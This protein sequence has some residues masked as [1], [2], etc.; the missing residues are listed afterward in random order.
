M[1]L[2]PAI[3]YTFLKTPEAN[4]DLIDNDHD[5][6][7]DEPGERSGLHT[8]M[9]YFSSAGTIR[10]P[11][12]GADIYNN[13]L[14]LWVD[15]EPITYGGVGREYSNS[16]SRFIFTGDPL[17]QSYW[18]AF[19]PAPNGE[20]PPF[21]PH[22]IRAMVTSGPFT[23][24]PGESNEFLIALV[25]A[26]GINHL[27]SVRKLKN[28]VANL[29]TTPDRYLTTGYQ[30]GQLEAPPEPSF[31]L[32]FDHNFPNPFNKK[33]TLRYS[34]PK[35]MQVRLAVYDLLGREVTVLAEGTREAGI[36]TQE[37]DGAQLRPG[38]YYARI[39]LDHLQFTRKM[40]RVP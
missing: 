28:I 27:D 32:G 38:I 2:P 40:V 34:L 17:T 29:Q 5:G 14:G 7:I 3:G 6:Q 8:A 11:S 25:W 30:P 24:A 31:V 20:W 4:A 37:F 9:I 16:I 1:I 22:D 35:T 33:T 26:Q 15:G 39:E 23:L 19:S 13:M 12:E 10:D 18:T 21:V 36:Y